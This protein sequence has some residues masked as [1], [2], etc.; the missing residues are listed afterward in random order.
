MLSMGWWLAWIKVLLVIFCRVSC[1]AFFL[2]VLSPSLLYKHVFSII[3]RVRY[4][5]NGTSSHLQKRGLYLW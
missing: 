2:W 4:G 3:F 5:I 1:L